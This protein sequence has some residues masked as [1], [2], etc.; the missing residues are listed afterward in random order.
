MGITTNLAKNEVGNL[1][2]DS[3]ETPE[4]KASQFL[5]ESS[6][7]Q[8]GT[9]PTEMR[10]PKTIH[11]SQ[12]AVANLSEAIRNFVSL[13]TEV[14]EKVCALSDKISE[15]AFEMRETLNSGGRIYFCGCGATGRLSISLE[16][17]WREE[18]K[19]LGLVEYTDS[20]FSFIAG[21][22]FALVKSIENFEDHPEFGVRQLHDLGFSSN[23]LFVG[24]TEGGETPFV[25]G[26][27]EEASQKS[28][29][30][31]F[32][33]FCNPPELLSKTVE[34]SERV[35]RNHQIRKIYVP[36]G[37]MALSGSTR[38]QATTAQMFLVGS[39]LFAVLKDETLPDS[40]GIEKSVESML[41]DL[42]DCQKHVD[43]SALA[44][45]VVIEANQYENKKYFVHET[46][47]FGITVL[48][49]TTERTPTFSL[50]PF[51]NLG[52]SAQLEV[53]GKPDLQ[54]FSWTYLSIPGTKTS[55]EAWEKVLGRRPL[56]LKWENYQDNF[57]VNK[58][59][60]FDFSE[61]GIANRVKKISSDKVLRFLILEDEKFISFDIRD[62]KN[63]SVLQSENKKPF[64]L[65][66]PNSILAKHLIVKCA[67]NIVSTLVMARLGRVK[68]NVMVYVR[69][70]NKK[71]IDRSI[72]YIRLLLE[73][74]GVPA[75]TYEEVCYALFREIEAAPIDEPIVLRTLNR[76][77]QYRGQNTNAK[78]NH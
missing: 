27:T 39:A 70:T 24:I 11:M 76:L 62:F 34:R 37:S 31:P 43:W 64:L 47:N 50:F 53:Q 14:I 13:D 75:F 49:D 3:S 46:N 65:A 55:A 10:H 35:I 73:D 45:Y 29:R 25:I 4:S 21:G 18:V 36:T 72:R 58:T 12:H 41:N 67:L 71:L 30:K 42:K 17:L 78:R 6:Q 48:T 69:P 74:A 5:S 19:R 51:E 57:G 33:V 1:K 59:L 56:C 54:N 52:D 22:D 38:L 9:L 60:G 40:L 61:K 44:D 28:N 20:V 26:A 7:F 32:F 15:L 23:D 63:K 2:Q 8:L 16:A 66:K 68:G 77:V